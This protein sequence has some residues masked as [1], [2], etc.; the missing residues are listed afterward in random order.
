MVNSGHNIYRQNAA[1][2]IIS[3]D[4]LLLKLYNGSLNFLKLAKRG[5]EEKNPKIS[6]EN[7]SKVIAI[8]TELD[9]ALD[10]EAGGDIAVNLS[11]L[12]RHIMYG[13]VDANLKNDIDTIGKMEH[14]LSEVKDGFEEAIRLNREK[15]VTTAA[16]QSISGNQEGLQFAV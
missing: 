7:I 13:L 16:P 14:L 2:A 9:C 4:Q 3:K 10:M 12:Y 5:I 8:L 1:N 15:P 11:S 6:G